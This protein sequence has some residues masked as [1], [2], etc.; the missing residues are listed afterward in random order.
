MD[1]HES[2]TFGWHVGHQLSLGYNLWTCQISQR[3]LLMKILFLFCVQL[4][5]IF[6]KGHIH[7]HAVFHSRCIIRSRGKH[8]CRLSC[9]VHRIDEQT[10]SRRASDWHLLRSNRPWT[11]RRRNLLLLLARCT[12]YALRSGLAFLPHLL[13]FIFLFLVVLGQVQGNGTARRGSHI[14]TDANQTITSLI[15]H[16]FQTNDDALEI[17]PASLL[18]VVADFAQI[19]CVRRKREQIAARGRK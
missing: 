6:S 4:H 10:L 19:D 8:P 5:E 14:F 12:A 18:N 11:I 15:E 2:C 3:C 17:C 9:P 13:R 1:T 16:V 7:W